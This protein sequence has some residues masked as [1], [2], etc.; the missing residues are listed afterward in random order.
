MDFLKQ[1]QVSQASIAS[2]DVDS[3][4]RSYFL[5]IYNYMASAL[6]LTGL[7]AYFGSNSPALIAILYNANEAGQ[8]TGLSGAGWLVALAP[9]GVSL[10]FGFKLQSMSIGAAKALFWGFAALMGLS[11]MSLFLAYTG[12]SIARVFFITAI[13]FGGMSLYGYT[14]QRDLTG[15]GSFLIMGAWG[16]FVGFI[17]N[18]FLQSTGFQF[19]LSAIGV[20]VFTGLIAYDTQ[21]LKRM[22]YQMSGGADMLAKASIMGALQLYL[23]FIN[24]FIML[25]RLVG[26]RR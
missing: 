18:M 25:M 3:G 17:V 13:T 7:V 5:Q 23:D 22:Y 6:L 14:T 21:N 9:I 26:D 20:L 4:L 2:A 1:S 10:F 19:V 12:A 15:F 8:I 11:L 24:L 16:L